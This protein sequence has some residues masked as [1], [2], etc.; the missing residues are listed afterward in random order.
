MK[1]LKRNSQEFQAK[2]VVIQKHKND[3]AV[4][5]FGFRRQKD[6]MITQ[7]VNSPFPNW[8]GFKFSLI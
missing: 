5:S 1:N 7:I 3:V 4:N 6:Q 2:K 8:G